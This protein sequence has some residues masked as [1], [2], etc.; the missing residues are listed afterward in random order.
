[1]SRIVTEAVVDAACLEEV[2]S[3]RR[4]LVLERPERDGH[5]FQAAEGPFRVY[6]RTVDVEPVGDEAS[7]V[8]QTVDY[9]LAVP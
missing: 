3:P 1:M 9:R 6:R 5:T 2:L 4:G 7:R 8:R